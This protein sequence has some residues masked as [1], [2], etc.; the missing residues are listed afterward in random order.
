[1]ALWG[2]GPM[3]ASCDTCAP[4]AL[5]R[6]QGF[7]MKEKQGGPG[8]RPPP[9][10]FAVC[11]WAAMERWTPAGRVVSPESDRGEVHEETGAEPWVCSHPRQWNSPAYG[12]RWT[13]TG[14][15]ALW[16]QK[17][18]QWTGGQVGT[19]R[20]SEGSVGTPEPAAGRVVWEGG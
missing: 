13:E 6:A 4:W 9:W 15:G 7:E 10:D 5:L 12:V 17:V 3:P 11:Q 19:G 1:M 8:P 20:S 18:D 2:Q 16:F 14:R